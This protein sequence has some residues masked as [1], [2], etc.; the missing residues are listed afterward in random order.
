MSNL[1]RLTRDAFYIRNFLSNK[2]FDVGGKGKKLNEIMVSYL[3]DRKLKYVKWNPRY[4]GLFTA[5]I[6]NSS[7]ILENWDDF[8]LYIKTLNK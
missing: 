3:R 4:K 1:Q 5:D 2:N 8:K 6:N 7:T